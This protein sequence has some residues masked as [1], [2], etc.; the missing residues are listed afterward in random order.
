MSWYQTNVPKK[1]AL[2]YASLISQEAFEPVNLAS[3]LGRFRQTPQLSEIAKVNCEREYGLDGHLYIRCRRDPLSYLRVREADDQLPSFKLE[4]RAVDNPPVAS[5]FSLLRRGAKGDIE[6]GHVIE[7]ISGL[8]REEILDDAW[9]VIG[10]EKDTVAA[11]F[12]PP[13]T[14]LQFLAEIDSPEFVQTCDYPM[15][16]RGVQGSFRGA[17]VIIDPHFSTTVIAGRKNTVVVNAG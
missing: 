9:R 6:G 14:Y 1:I 11:M 3:S 10:E 8:L 4:V 16:K 17:A 13:Q 5:Q 15:L 12:I 7:E 2:E